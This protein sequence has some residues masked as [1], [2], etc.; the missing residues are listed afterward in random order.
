MPADR[1]TFRSIR[2]RAALLAS[3]LV[4]VALIAATVYTY[5]TLHR[6]LVQ[7]AEARATRAA[8]QLAAILG[9]PIP[10]R[11]AELQ[12]AA[13]EAAPLR[14]ALLNPTPE[15]EKAA[16]QHLQAFPTSGTQSPQ[17]MDLWTVGGRLLWSRRIPE[18]GNAVPPSQHPPTQ[19]G[20]QPFTI[21]GDTVYLDAVVAIRGEDS[22]QTLGYLLSRR[23]AT[24]PN[25]PATL[26]RLVGDGGR[27]LV[28]NQSGSV[29]TDLGEPVEALPIDASRPGLHR[30]EDADGRTRL[31]GVAP[32]PAT[33]LAIVAE[34]PE[35][36]FVA[37]AWALLE[38]LA[39]VGVVFILITIVVVWS[40]SARVTQP[41]DNLTEALQQI[42][43]GD[44]SRRVDTGAGSEV[45]RLG[46]AFNSMA[47]KIEAALR[48]LEAQALALK[49]E[50]QRKATMMN[51]ALD[52]IVT[53]DTRGQLT[54]CNP[55]AA[56]VFQYDRSEILGR[57]LGTLLG[58]P[59]F[60]DY[61]D[62][63]DYVQRT[64]A[65][66][67]GTRQEWTGVRSDGTAFPAEAAVVA[68]RTGGHAGFAAFIRDLS[69]QKAAEASV[70]RGIILEEENRRVQEASR[71][72]SEFLANMSHELRTPLNAI[73]GFAELLYDGQVR[74]DMPEFRDFMHDILRSGQHLLQLI[75]DVL[76]L[77]KVEAG[78]L[79]FHPEATSLDQIVSESIAMLR[80][81][82]A[83]KQL[84]IEHVIDPAVD[85]VFVDR[86]RLKQVL[87]N[88]LSN[89]IK[90]TPERGRVSVRV[91]AEGDQHFRVDVVDT[92][93]GIA[94]ADLGR[95]FIEF[96]QLEAGAAKKH[97]GTGLGLA[98]TRRLVEAQGGRVDVASIAGRGST[99]TAVL[100]RRAIGGT[101]LAG[102][103]SIPSTR[104]G[105]P[106]VLV[107]EDD[108]ADQDAIVSTL[109]GA[110]FNIETANSRAQAAQ[111]LNARAFDA[112][113]L[114]LILPDANG[115]D[116][117][118]DIRASAL[119]GKVPVVVITVVADGG[120]VTG[121][122]VHDILAKPV[123]GMAVIGALERAGIA[124]S[125]SGS[126][127]VVD[128]DPGSL[129]LMAASLQQLGYHSI[130]VPRAIDGL[131]LSEREAPLAVV[132]D[133]QMPELD[134]FGFLDQFRRIPSCEHIPVI[135]WTV[136]DLTRTDLSRLKKSV[137]GV[138]NKGQSGRSVVDELRRFVVEREARM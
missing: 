88:Y 104:I 100:P 86:G 2:F 23:V 103:R 108:A 116:V 137:Q 120:V 101:P 48:E 16:I 41:L 133:L 70:R 17:I 131:R 12:R 125:G 96:N 76:D 35:D 109:V 107:I 81:L 19:A 78:R 123:D 77:S 122:A 39:W 49:E 24:N 31:V 42:S 13:D 37:P 64:D 106:T 127:L 115:A 124:I 9:P 117:L 51:V 95:L 97:Q 75:N 118:R 71:L 21:I 43:G 113:T 18:T 6:D 27:G 56:R 45:G 15:T 33:P 61:V 129:R 85:R 112:I 128:D 36:F 46:E 126:V 7:A 3:I 134:G 53:A 99:F 138:M 114:D 84:T 93:V 60:N 32:L 20:V 4:A 11:L 74:P 102:P 14:R 44:F 59:Q 8:A 66:R 90:F 83:Q 10:A 30:Y 1:L 52:G 79:E 28:A 136:K 50:D 72:K 34:F 82:A 29:W 65:L 58:L 105:A 54:E 135:V 26:N 89:A 73:I 22:G 121:F 119:N 40:A 55:A 69:D 98:L 68:I 80:P 111:K 57:N 5:W 92:G 67:L 91:A 47:A 94:A 132:L 25:S 62:L 63:H 38:R 87:Y 110:G 130:C